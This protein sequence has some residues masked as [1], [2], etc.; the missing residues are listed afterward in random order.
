MQKESKYKTAASYAEAWFEAA[1]ESN[2][3][4]KVFAEV[5]LIRESLE[6]DALLW[7]TMIS[8]RVSEDFIEDIAHKAK[9]SVISTNTLKLIAENGRL[10]LL[11]QIT[12]DFVHLFY[13][14]KGIVEVMVD[15]AVALNATQDKK[16]R[17]VLKDK[18]QSEIELTYRIKPEVLG[19]LA[20][21]FDSFLID[22]TLASKLKKF[23]KLVT[24]QPI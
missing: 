18:L 22:D 3:E 21:S 13:K 2:S 14:K 16:L 17:K 4:E 15:T 9:L 7:N 5:K 11:E 23:E 8:S 12:D 19:G 6:S 1:T 10:N 24:E 20:I